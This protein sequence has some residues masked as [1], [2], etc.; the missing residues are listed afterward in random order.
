[1]EI[2]NLSF[3]YDMHE[4]GGLMNMGILGFGI[5]TFFVV[6]FIILSNIFFI[7]KL[8]N[9]NLFLLKRYG[10]LFCYHNL[11]FTT[12]LVTLILKAN[13]ADSYFQF[14]LIADHT[15]YIFPPIK[16]FGIY[17]LSYIY[18]Y[19][20]YFLN[21]DFYSITFFF[22]C[23]GFWVLVLFDTVLIKGEKLL[24]YKK[25][26][27]KYYL[28]F[29]PSLSLWHTYLGKEVL[30]VGLLIFFAYIYINTSRKMSFL[31]FSLILI[32]IFFIRPHFAFIFSLSFIFINVLQIKSIIIKILICL[33]IFPVYLISAKHLLGQETHF[34]GIFQDILKAAEAQRSLWSIS[35]GWVDTSEMNYIFIYLNFLFN[36]LFNF[37]GLRNIIL[38]GENLLILTI[39]LYYSYMNRKKFLTEN[40]FFLIFFIIGSIMLSLFTAETGIYWRQK[41]LLLPY[42]FIFLVNPINVAKKKNISN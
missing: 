17:T 13:D 12:M 6:L 32:L 34:F 20:Y 23:V 42:L 38:S 4:T 15:G 19:F 14:G 24:D 26:D 33:L 35:S 25:M 11:I 37:G 36:P 18:R 9:Q 8:Y 22:N 27:L 28:I 21:L 7:F 10:F 30:T 31:F 3:S 39:I 2:L 16:E 1:M 5:D 29:F 41:W 40:Y